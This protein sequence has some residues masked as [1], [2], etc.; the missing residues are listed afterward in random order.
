M[1]EPDYQSLNFSTGWI[2]DPEE[3]DRVIRENRISQFSIAAG[4]LSGSIPSSGVYN[5]AAYMDKV[6]GS[7]EWVYN[8][9][10]CG[11][12]VANGAG[13]AAEILVAQDIVENQAGNPGRIDCMS[14]Y[15]GSRV[16][17]GGG[18]IWGQGSVG[19]W[20]AQYLQKYGCLIRKKYAS[21]DLT[22]YS[23][24][25]CCSSYASKGVPDDLEPIARQHPIKAYA[26]VSNWKD[27]VA[28]ITSGYPVT[29][30]SN[31]GFAY[32][33]DEK[34][35]ARPQG[36]WPHQM[37]FVAV[38]LNDESAVIQN[39]WGKDWISGPKPE[40]MPAGSFKVTPATVDS[41]LKSRDSFAFSD[42]SGWPKKEIP[43][44][45][46]NW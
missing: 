11:S 8:Q 19:V 31:Q 27:L 22:N 14:I 10:N 43:W 17:I 18:K 30:A 44:A 45:K 39:S 46:L 15:W 25:L 6:W 23:S 5:L 37:T 41:M 26:P 34:G 16:E 20:A 4:H 36:S 9:G 7:S 12:C 28:A 38:D 29:V 35:Y 40:W 13:L 32:K 2:N 21:V 33:R 24:A 3:V 1:S 42:L